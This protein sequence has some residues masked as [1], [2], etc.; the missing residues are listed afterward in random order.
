MKVTNFERC[1]IEVEVHKYEDGKICI[2]Y[3]NPDENGDDW[4]YWLTP[5]VHPYDDIDRIIFDNR[6]PP[7]HEDDPSY[8]TV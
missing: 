7:K 2:L 3:T 5:G 6:T 1:E 4:V 8:G